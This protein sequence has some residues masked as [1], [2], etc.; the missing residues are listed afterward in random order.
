MAAEAEPLALYIHWPFCLSK[1]PY[2]DFN[3]HV[4][5][6]IDN[7][8]WR[9]ALLRE[10]DHAADTLPGRVVTSV[11][12]GGG[13]PSLMAP[14]TAAALLDR[15]AERWAVDDAEI[16]LEANPT[17]VEA[18]RLADF[19]AAGVNRV[20]LGVQALDDDALKFLGRGHDASEAVAAVELAAR[21]FPRW[22]ID[23]IYARPGQGVAAWRAELSRALDLVG[24]H[25]SVYQLT[26]E[27]GTPFFAA[28]RDGV[29]DLPD[30]DGGR[31]L[32][33]ET[34]TVLAEAGL[35]AYEISNHAR[36]GSESRHNLA[37]WRYRDYAGIGPGAH[38]RVTVD[39]ALF[40]TERLRA[41]EAWLA[42]VE[43]DG[44]GTR[45]NEPVGPARRAEEMLMMGLRLDEGV[46]RAAF[47]R[48]AGQPL[49]NALDREAAARLATAGLIEND[50]AGLR[51]TA[52]GRPVLD[53]I[54]AALIA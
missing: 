36:R 51:L 25:I 38:G 45:V 19:R 50:S 18:G 14:G 28:H 53:A 54:L 32:Y 2:C 9:A 31:A 4:A 7:D 1:C 42:A 8:R 37:Y 23:L 48:R 49:D 40:A 30:Q 47:E 24:D 34:Q 10:L 15:V 39:G 20:S 16:T 26:I 6:A 46:D 41:P 17:S 21:L 13:T 52:A 35:P 44:H 33:D 29:F 11:F 3:S 12:F 27:R 43:A 22:S 5:D